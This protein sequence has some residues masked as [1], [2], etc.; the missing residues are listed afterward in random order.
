M[1]DCVLHHPGWKSKKKKR[2]VAFTACHKTRAGE[3]EGGCDFFRGSKGFL[4]TMCKG[5]G[6]GLEGH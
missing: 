5:K 6:A 2:G 4:R 1:A 3:R